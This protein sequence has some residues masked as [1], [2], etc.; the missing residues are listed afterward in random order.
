M[1]SQNNSGNQTKVWQDLIKIGRFGYNFQSDG[2]FELR[3]NNS[4][5]DSLLNLNEFFLL[6]DEEK[7]RFA[8]VTELKLSGY[9]LTG[10]FRD[11]AL[12]VELK[13]A[14]KVWFAIDQ[15]TYDA[16][17]LPSN[18]LIGLALFF[19]EKKIGVISEV[20]DNGAHDV[21]VVTLDE[22]GK[23]FMIPDV[24]EFVTEIDHT[25]HRVLAHNIQQLIDL[26]EE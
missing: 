1:S 5:Q 17:V 2:R 15:E 11:S 9:R 4:F 22:D 21:L 10:R 12:V 26:K 18:K 19:D 23:N 7:V 6:I 16:Q 14:K 8:T 13:K 20:F 25:N 3:V 24:S